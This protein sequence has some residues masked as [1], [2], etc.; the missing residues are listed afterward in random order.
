LDHPITTL[1]PVLLGAFEFAF[2]RSDAR[3]L[4]V[5]AR[6]ALCWAGENGLFGYIFYDL[7][8]QRIR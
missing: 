7:I 1:S 5:L 4:Y 6:Y 2:R 3:L 8:L